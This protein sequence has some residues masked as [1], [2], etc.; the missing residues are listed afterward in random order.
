ML[1]LLGWSVHA[2][3]AKILVFNAHGARQTGEEVGG[4]S[5]ED[6]LPADLVQSGHPNLA[7]ANCYNIFKNREYINLD[8]EGEV[9][10]VFQ[11][12]YFGN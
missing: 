9:C 11:V 1:I 10:K 12:L 6:L 3:R 8:F 2:I 4:R 5:E 7:L